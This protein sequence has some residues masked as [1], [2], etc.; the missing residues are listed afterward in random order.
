MRPLTLPILA[1]ALLAAGC[2]AYKKGDSHSA[3]AAAAAPR[4]EAPSRVHKLASGLVYEDIVIGQGTMA[5]T[6]STVTVHYTGRLMD[7][8]QFDSSLNRGVP[9]TLQLGAGRVIQGW[10]QGIKGMRPG[11]KR[12]LTIPPDLGYGASGYGGGVIPPNATLDFDIELLE[13]K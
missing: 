13:V 1:L 12:R 7:G 8:T 10:E 9:Y 2:G 4:Q 3:P 5:E 6:G 11:G